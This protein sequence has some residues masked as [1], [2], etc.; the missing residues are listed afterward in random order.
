LRVL[1][2]EQATGIDR[3]DA[4]AK[5][6]ANLHDVKI[7]LEALQAKLGREKEAVA[8]IVALRRRIAAG[9]ATVSDA[10]D[11][12]D[13]QLVAMQLQRLNKGLEALQEDDPLVTVCVDSGTVASVISDWTGIPV[14]KMMA[15]E[16]HTVLHLQDR[17]AERLVGQP[18][19]LDAI[20][21][22]VR[23]FRAD[24]DD[25]GKPVGVFMLVG[26]SGV[27]KTE[28]AIALADLLYGGERNMVTVN[29]S[30]FQE[31]HSVSSLKGAP[32]G[33]VG[34]G[35]GGV[36]TEAVRRRPYSVVLLDEMEKAHPDVLELFFQVFDKGV[37]DDGEGVQIDFKNTL[38]L[39]T[40]NAAQDIITDACA[41][42][43][44]PSAPEL[45]E[46]L[47]PALLKQFSPAFLGRLVL[48]PYYPLGDA[49]IMGIVKLKLGRLADRIS[50]N[51]S[52]HFTFDEA[53]ARTITDRCTEV[54]SGARNVDNILTQS[55]L[56]ELS[57]LV[58]ERMALDQPFSAIHMSVDGQGRF[59]YRFSADAKGTP[60]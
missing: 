28:T 53:V 51:H 1:R 33:Y 46:R 58:L 26:P 2:H 34:Y 41:N 16:L 24:L 5:A 7:R 55:V 27:G 40:S 25:P 35:R 3:V 14:G 4:I 44:R 21:R 29:M 39:L 42:G 13:P 43:R 12:Q 45:V 57:S 59:A 36:L 47:R 19:A 22:R 9:T 37:M 48:V 56:P 20:A 23:T 54:D 38:I 49:Q 31:A 60:L 18:Q 15:D 6:Q 32:P 50:L 11:E 52:A 17:M 8:E 30:E 10:D